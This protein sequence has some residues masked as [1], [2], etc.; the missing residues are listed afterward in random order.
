[1]KKVSKEVDKTDNTLKSSN[2]KLKDLIGKV[3]N[4][5]IQYRKPN[6]L[7]L[8][9]TLLLLVIGLIAVIINMIKK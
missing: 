6:K 1:M 2:K 7:C 5:N 9:I 3:Q 4:I 8:D